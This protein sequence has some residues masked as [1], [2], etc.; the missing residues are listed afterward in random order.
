MAAQAGT[1]RLLRGINDRA[2]TDLLL[3]RGP[4]SRRSARRTLRACRSPPS[5]QLLARLERA[6]LVVVSGSSAGASGPKA[7]LYEIN[8]DAAHVAGLDVTPTRILSGVADISG[9]IVGEFELPTPRRGGAPTPWSG[10]CGDRGRPGDAGLHRAI[11]PRRHRHTGRIRSG[12]GAS[13]VCRHLPGWH[14]PDLLTRLADAIGA[15]A[16]GRERR[17][18]CGDRRAA[19]GSRPREHRLR[20][21]VGRG[22]PRCGHRHRLLAPPGRHRRAGEVGFLPLPGTPWCETWADQRRRIPGA[23]GREPGSRAR[24]G[25]R[26]SRRPSRDRRVSCAGHAGRRRRAAGRPVPPHRTRPRGHRLRDRSRARDPHRERAHRRRQRLLELVSTEF[27]DLSVARPRFEL[28]GVTD[29]PVLRG[30]LYSALGPH[31]RQRLRH[32]PVHPSREQHVSAT[33]TEE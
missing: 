21:A 13:P 27:A 29:K 9:R 18:P 2:A 25:A 6:G 26:H 8:A 15:P 14:D 24:P 20:A 16:G 17:Q 4:L 12:D 7:Q 30:A 31:P 23:R 11:A 22:R 19:R 1:P 5:S 32:H 33:S 10:F 3:D 28:S